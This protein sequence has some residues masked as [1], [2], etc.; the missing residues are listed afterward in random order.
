V[1]S[2]GLNSLVSTDKRKRATTFVAITSSI[3]ILI[4]IF[5]VG[6]QAIAQ[7][8][9]PSQSFG[10]VAHINKHGSFILCLDPVCNQATST[11]I[12]GNLSIGSN[13]ETTYLKNMGNY[14]FLLSISIVSLNSTINSVTLTSNY[15]GQVITPTQVIPIIWNMSTTY[16]SPPGNYAFDVTIS[17]SG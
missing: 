2:A 7:S 9:P 8:S 5:I 6:F 1:R 10:G 13:L 17:L 16:Y 12:F 11:I 3:L 14:N 15:S 4:I